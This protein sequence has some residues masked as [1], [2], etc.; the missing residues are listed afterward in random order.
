MI[1]VEAT[2]HDL[3]KF[4]GKPVIL[5]RPGKFGSRQCDLSY[6]SPLHGDLRSQVILVRQLPPAEVDVL[7]DDICDEAEKLGHSGTA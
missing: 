3:P 2:V 6:F 5:M 1:G 7:C 4:R